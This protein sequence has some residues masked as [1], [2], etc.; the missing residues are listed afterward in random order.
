ME[1][2]PPN[3]P[4]AEPA[5][6]PDPCFTHG[7]QDDAR[8][9]LSVR[10]LF[11]EGTTYLKSS[12]S[13]P[14]DYFGYSVAISGDMAVVSAE[15]EDSSAVGVNGDQC[16]NSML[17]VGAAYVFRHKNGKWRQE[18]YL[19]PAS[20]EWVGYFGTKVAASG[21]TI[22]V[23]SYNGNDDGTQNANPQYG[24]N[25]NLTGSATVFERIRG[26]WKQTALLKT[27][28]GWQMSRFSEIAI[29]G[30]TIALSVFYR[31]GTTT[32][33]I[34][35]YT[36]QAAVAIFRRNSTGWYQE[37]VLVPSLRE[38]ASFPMW[39]LEF[40]TS[41]DVSGDL[42]VASVSGWFR[43][44]HSNVHIYRRKSGK[45]VPQAELKHSKFY[46]S[47][48]D[49]FGYFGNE[50][51][52]AGSSIVVGA[53]KRGGV[54]APRGGGFPTDCSVAL[55]SAKA[56]RWRFQQTLSIPSG[57]DCRFFGK[58][59][60]GS[61]ELIAVSANREIP[62]CTPL[63]GAIYLYTPGEQGWTLHERVQSPYPNMVREFG[64]VLDV[65]GTNVIT[66]SIKEDSGATS[67][68]SDPL[69]GRADASGAAYIYSR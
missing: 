18:A 17:G 10:T 60:A 61:S 4:V 7:S 42:L 67:V 32:D 38:E 55:Y 11:S 9:P 14:G 6:E 56:G 53:P 25:H 36:G 45:W 2:L 23:K 24:S 35:Y 16:D 13:D 12:N 39:G 28:G 49:N 40:G 46:C 33:P 37:T 15:R 31:Q 62:W 44:S 20:A 52:I 63:E 58:A 50:V 48:G 51:A 22:V 43:C 57:P 1:P 47:A 21:D 19:K 29:S 69:T 68:N 59:V 64:M 65:S 34:S 66:S 26:R 8:P 3:A 30:D 54:N 41:I 5:A 27:S